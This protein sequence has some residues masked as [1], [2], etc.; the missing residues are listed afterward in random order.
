MFTGSTATGRYR[1]P[2]GRAAHRRLGRARRQEPHD[3]DDADLDR[4]VDGAVR[5]VRQHRAALHLDRAH[6]RRGRSWTSS[7]RRSAHGRR[8]GVG[9]ELR[10]RARGGLARLAGPAGH[11][12]RATSRTP[13]PR[14]P[15]CWPGQGPPRPG[16]AVLRAHRARRRHDGDDGLRGETF[17]PV[18][19][20]LPGGVGRRG[21]G[22]GQRHRLRPQRQRVD[23]ATSA[24]AG[25]IAPRLQAGTVNVNDGYA[26]WAC[27]D[28]PMGGLEGL[29][30]RAG[31]TG[32]RALQVHRAPDHRPCA[33]KRGRAPHRPDGR[34][35]GLR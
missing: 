28:A 10:L 17:G 7:P 1:P 14:A 29:G 15:A 2:G 26:A 13:W 19:A 21:G 27:I 32:G 3:L 34:S 23:A 25:A 24:G 20:R 35:F 33:R 12:H 31:A 9:A 11:G 4:A 22:E 8:P 18:V 30:P 16:P 6:V 5:V